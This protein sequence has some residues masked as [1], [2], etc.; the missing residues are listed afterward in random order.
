MNCSLASLRLLGAL[1]LS[2]LALAGSLKAAAPNPAGFAIHRGTNLSHWLS[3]DFHWTTKQAFLTERDIQRIASL[4]FD[5]VRLPVDEI[6]LWSDTG[7]PNEEAFSLLL[8]AI[9]WCRKA[10]L[11]V[12]VDLHTVRSHHFNA[13]NE[14]HA[15]A[16]SLFD[17]PAAQERFL[18]L[19]KQL[20]ARLR[21]Q[22]VDQVAYEPL[23]EPV[24]DEASQWNQLVSRTIAQIRQN[25]PN[26]VVIIG[27]NRWQMPSNVPQL[28]VPAGDRN[29]ILS[30]H[31]YVPMLFTHHKADWVPIKI[32]TG[33]VHYPGPVADAATLK[34]LLANP[35]HRLTDLVLGAGDNWGP[36]RLRQEFLPA[37]KRAK[38]LGLQLYCGEFGALPT[39][40]RADRLAYYRDI[41]G[42][43]EAEGLAWANWEYKGDF[44]ILEWR[45]TKDLDT[46]VDQGLVNA[47]FQRR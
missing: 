30:M 13:A 18:G 17:S 22:P 33:P 4:G 11:R 25:E 26:R 9:G 34:S 7:K 21:E 42:V 1:A 27:A 37:I 8:Q 14:E 19:W 46:P 45:G 23:N 15:Q 5:H 36:E 41:V 6:E 29:I 35:D 2:G 24:A 12:I 39:V 28:E 40:A 38:E 47:L 31:T 10:G 16:N 32:Y 3:Q 44:G 20:A 43:F